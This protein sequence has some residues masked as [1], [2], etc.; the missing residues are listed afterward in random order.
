MGGAQTYIPTNSVGG[1]RFLHTLSSLCYRLFMMAILTCVRWFLIVI[2]TCISLIISDV[3]HLICLLA[4]CIS[5][6]EKCL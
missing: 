1:F 2:L 6:L 5:S 3:G 4:I